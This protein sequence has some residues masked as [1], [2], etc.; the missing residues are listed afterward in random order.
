MVRTLDY[1]RL[2]RQFAPVPESNE[3]ADKNQSL[4]NWGLLKPKSWDD[5]E[6][7]YRCVIL[8]EA[9]AGKTE[10]LYH[11]AEHLQQQG[12]PAFFIRIEDID[13]DLQNA[14][15]IG[16][17]E[18]FC[19]WLQSTQEAWFFLDSVDESRLKN[20]KAFEKAMRRFANAIG[21]GAH[22]A[23]IY[24]SSRPYAWR[25]SEDR[26]LLDLILFHPAAD[27][28]TDVG[29][30]YRQSAPPSALSIYIL[31]P[32]DLERIRR[33]CNV[34][35]VRDV[36]HLLQEIERANLW[37]LAERPFDL[38]AILAKWEKDQVLDSR[39]ELLRFVIE[40]RLEDTHN[41]DRHQSQPLNL[42]RA[43]V[44]ARCLAAAGILTGQVNL[45]VPDAS[46]DKPGI[47]PTKILHDW[48]P[49]DVRVLL[50][51]GIFNDVIYGAVR[52]RNRDV[53]E[54]LAAEWFR[55][56]LGKEQ[57]RNRI[58]NLFFGEKYGEIVLIP[59][60]R[61]I[62]PWLILLDDNILAR[63]IK[64]CPEIAIEEGDPSKLH[65][66]VRRRILADI[67][68]RISSGEEV[69]SVD[70]RSS[71]VRIANH[72]LSSDARQFIDNYF[73]NDKAIYFL[74]RL[75]WQGKMSN[76]VDPLLGIVRNSSRDLAARRSSALAVMACGSV[77]QKTSLW[78]SLNDIKDKM[79]HELL[80]ILIREATPE[81]VEKLLISLGKLV[82]PP[83]TNSF[84]LGSTLHIYI[85]RLA[86]GGY[87]GALNQLIEGLNGYLE[88]QLDRDPECRISNEFCWLS[89]FALHAVEQIINLW[90]DTD[91]PCERVLGILLNASPYRS[92]NNGMKEY[93]F[94]SE[95]LESL[96]PRRAALN[97]ALYWAS[98]ERKRAAWAETG[99][100][101][102][103]WPVA[104][105]VRYW[106]FDANSFP[107]LIEYIES[108]S[109]PDDKIIALRRAF[110]VY[111]KAR[112][113]NQLLTSLQAA[114]AANQLLREELELLLNPPISESARQYQSLFHEI[115][116]ERD[117]T[118]LQMDQERSSWMAHV[119]AN[120]DR[121]GNRLGIN[122][123]D[124]TN[125]IAGLMHEL[126]QMYEADGFCADY[127]DWKLLMPDFGE[128]VALAYRAAAIN[129]W[130]IYRSALRSEGI[131][132][133]NH[134]YSLSFAMAGLE[135]EAAEID[136]FPSDL[137]EAEVCHALRY[138]T[139]QMNGFPSWLE[140]LH[141][142]FPALVEKAVLKELVWELEN[143]QLET[144]MHYILG[145]L[146]Y[147]GP[148]LHPALA[149]A[150]L[151]WIEA[152]PLR[153]RN[154]R[155][156]CLRILVNGGIEP[157]RLVN[158][159]SQQ[160]A[161]S[162]DPDILPGWYALL[163]ACDPTTGI[164]QVQQWLG[165]LSG[166]AAT[167]AAQLFIVEL[168]GEQHEREGRPCFMFFH[169][170]DHLKTLYLLMYQYIRVEDDIGRANGAVRCV[171]IRD[172]AQSARDMLFDLLSK[173]PG[174]PSY[175][176]ITALIKE[177]PVPDYRDWFKTLAY[178]R[179]E[180]D[181]DLEAWSVEQFIEF[182]Q[183]LT[184]T[185]AT[186]RQLFDLVV[187]R[188]E[189][190]KA[191]LECG[192]DSPWRT[193]QRVPRETEMRNLIAGWLNQQTSYGRYTIA[194]EAE[195]ANAQRPDIW[196]QSPIVAS[197]VPIELKLLENWSGHELC[198][199]LRD[200][201]AG[202]YLR[203]VTAG[204]G[205]YLLVWRG[206]EDEQKTWRISESLVQLSELAEALKLY[207]HSIAANY[208]G[209]DD[210]EV[211]VIDLGARAQV[212]DS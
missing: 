36:E 39:L 165:N 198:E 169:T 99:E 88:Q 90:G 101:L 156:H 202:D 69:R 179:A 95:N 138:I 87:L 102:N 93:S 20:P 153:I 30:N 173:I 27:V 46:P 106:A 196:V 172:H 67:V 206:V 56:L 7:E 45:N 187:H 17:Q 126:K 143:A 182:E 11:R 12:K 41:T 70:D 76:C 1:I 61:P 18:D 203:E 82:I 68:Q 83:R 171:G 98:I 25:A 21:N 193:W 195:L 116:R 212:S 181:S 159:A 148:W 66:Q 22:R 142:V 128:P 130:R 52:F 189:D 78:Q 100:V 122:Q 186:H 211:I 40:K 115:S 190:L 60:L 167:Q 4:F 133:R 162:N 199:R 108:R 89:E 144:P 112:A 197:S 117:E 166:E 10:E 19:S 51:R 31:C 91:P 109:N 105:D 118:Q 139:W 174:K 80:E 127:A 194:Q 160:I 207:W 84:L 23:H 3:A 38:E 14:F 26:K 64:I 53:R 154:N 180:E 191:W 8:A 50:E 103:D 157:A 65:L 59:R 192:N 57:S 208:P 129:H 183:S 131:Q 48:E 24:I 49:G 152:N 97:D 145:P 55:D 47:E 170:A 37:S 210:I 85:D 15:E 74:S 163:V 42:E 158:L 168:M 58:E 43:K 35:M 120:P 137:S 201:L 177:H 164:S 13:N 132:A 110:F 29:D 124:I 178:R 5:I 111:R 28:N 71:L 121:I 185:P 200:Q 147:Y 107:R 73:S 9:G 2:D 205:V 151:Q 141:Q 134:T 149:P 113:P 92:S 54:L 77:E 72:A 135:I 140:R 33:Y 81:S 161:Q 176:A 175:V 94:Y 155:N 119:R 16:D 188:L 6:A 114:V 86:A 209:V 136:G 32:L 96:I 34:R 62:L 75:V 79:P 146:V 184:M 125:D 150:L 123:G 204:C 63:A 104:Y 44:G